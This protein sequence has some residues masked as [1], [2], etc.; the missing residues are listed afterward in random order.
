MQRSCKICIYNCINHSIFGP[1]IFIRKSERHSEYIAADMTRDVNRLKLEGHVCGF[2]PI[3][4]L[5]RL[6]RFVLRICDAIWKTLGH[7][8]L[9]TISTHQSYEGSQDF[10]VPHGLGLQIGLPFL[11]SKKYCDRH[12]QAIMAIVAIVD[13]FSKHLQTSPNISKLRCRL[14]A[15]HR[16]LSARG[17]STGW[18]LPRFANSGGKGLS[19]WAVTS[20]VV[21]GA[22]SRTQHSLIWG[23]RIWKG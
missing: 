17:W 9:F 3:C 22:L 10:A 16:N 14:S 1:A 7:S 2:S 5:L 11:N 23:L 18:G 4:F 19:R 8:L 20:T 15:N 12:R 21:V 13:R 6:L